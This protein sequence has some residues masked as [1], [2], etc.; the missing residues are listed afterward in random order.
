MVR[1]G[2][3]QAAA[4]VAVWSTN[5]LAA[6]FALAELS[7]PQ[8]LLCQFAGALGCL[9]LIAAFD[10]SARPDWREAFRARWIITGVVGV[11]G[12]V[13]LQYTAFAT[14][15]IVE[16]N[17]LSYS[18]PVMVALWGVLVCRDGA[19]LAAAGLT[20]VAFLGTAVLLGALDVAPAAASIGHLLALGAALCMAGYS[21]ATR[22]C[23]QPMS[24]LLPAVFVGLIGSLTA[25]GIELR[26]VH[27]LG[28]ALAAFYIGIAP[29]GLGYLFWTRAMRRGDP[30]RLAIFG[31]MTPVLSTSLLLVFGESITMAAL[32]GGCI[33]LL[34][35][36]GALLLEPARATR[37]AR[38]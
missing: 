4:A 16:A 23:T 10:H 2:L 19:R 29:M 9:A 26:P 34:V 1:A 17:I 38:A 3:P 20:L 21:I 30:A 28:A 36:F 22:H 7:V 25:V 8:T 14:A 24:V 18:W 12:T 31:Y 6:R 37:Q 27:S 15:P 11:V 35:N 33:I 32:I 5:A 13:T